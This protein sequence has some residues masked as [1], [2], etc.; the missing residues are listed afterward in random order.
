M[1]LRSLLKFS[2][3]VTVLAILFSLSISATAQIDFKIGT[4]TATNS[5]T[6]APSPIHDWYDGDKH[7]FLYL[8]SE[9][10]AAGMGPGI[11]T[12]IKWDVKNT[13]GQGVVPGYQLTVGTTSATS[14]T[15]WS[16][17]ATTTIYGPANY[18]ATTGMNVFT[19]PTPLVWNGTDNIVVQ[20]CHGVTGRCG[21]YT[22]NCSVEYTSTS[23]TSGIYYQR[24]C[25]GSQC[26][27]TSYSTTRRSNII[28]SWAAPCAGV[29]SGF[30]VAGPYQVCPNR[31]FSLTL[32][33]PTLSN[34]SY[35][36]QFSNNGTSWSNFAGIGATT[37]IL[38]DSITAPRWYRCIIKC[39]NSGLTFTTP[40][41]K[42][43]ISPF[44]YCY[45]VSQAKKC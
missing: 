31:L 19:F 42:V 21:G 20:T 43:G 36:W 5:S 27:A 4:G 12:A 24:D 16:T 30:T 13:N 7:Q 1:R 11:I 22:R 38:S 39:D 18:T 26:G 10:V 40:A 17:A 34:L 28:F 37:A 45:C 25:S 35:Q 29:P 8:A 15:G 14:L 23:F 9:M 32:A 41:K 2:K 44:Y 33:G 3:L 6:G